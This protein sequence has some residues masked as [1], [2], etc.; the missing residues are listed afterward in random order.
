MIRNIIELYGLGAI[1]ISR[2][3]GEPIEPPREIIDVEYEDLS[4]QTDP[5]TISTQN[6]LKLL[7]I[8]NQKQYA[9]SDNKQM[10]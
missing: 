10:P 4:D 8:N 2:L 3:F 9:D 1:P 5:K 7:E 6:E